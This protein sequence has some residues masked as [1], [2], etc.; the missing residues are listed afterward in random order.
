MKTP[1][2]II[3]GAVAPMII[4][5]EHKT[6]IDILKTIGLSEKKF[7]AISAIAWFYN[8]YQGFEPETTLEY[9]L[10]TTDL[11]SYFNDTCIP[12]SDY[13]SLVGLCYYLFNHWDDELTRHENYFREYNDLK[14][15]RWLV[16]GFVLTGTKE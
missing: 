9:L 16:N 13:E 6:G 3:I 14:V 7:A 8:R 1:K 15:K 5:S 4:M 12:I 10:D 11:F 2:E